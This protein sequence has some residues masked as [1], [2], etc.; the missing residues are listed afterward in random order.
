MAQQP[1]YGTPRP[2]AMQAW[3]RVGA[4]LKVLVNRFGLPPAVEFGPDRFGLVQ[5][6][7]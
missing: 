5:K 6:A 2:L 7:L 1:H 3:S 4:A